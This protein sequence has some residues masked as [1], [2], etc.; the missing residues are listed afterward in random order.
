MSP[1]PTASSSGQS[2]RSDPSD[3]PTLHGSS[4]LKQEF[5]EPHQ[6]YPGLAARVDVLRGR[7]S[8]SSLSGASARQDQTSSFFAPT[9]AS[10]ARSQSAAFG[11]IPDAS[12][13]DPSYPSGRVTSYGNPSHVDLQLRRPSSQPQLSLSGFPS[14]TFPGLPAPNAPPAYR[15]GASGGN[16]A[17]TILAAASRPSLG[18]RRRSVLVAPGETEPSDLRAAQPSL[19]ITRSSFSS[20]PGEPSPSALSPYALLQQ[21]QQQQ[22]YMDAASGVEPYASTG[23]PA[24]R[25]EGEPEMRTEEA[26]YEGDQQ[27]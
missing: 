26:K 17:N 24:G 21:Q 23:Q 5:S 22:L 16:A 4:P 14:Q 8:E 18:G 9:H 1:P 25:G 7:P 11:N 15:F 10:L 19:G 3:F 13:G 27:I 12:S 20:S 2:W 6:L